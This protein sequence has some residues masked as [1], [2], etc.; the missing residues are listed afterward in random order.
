VK[1][2]MQDTF[3]HQFMEHKV[4]NEFRNGGITPCILKL[5]TIRRWVVSFMFRPPNHN[6]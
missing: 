3:Y 1:E 2:I 6:G 4:I 5:A